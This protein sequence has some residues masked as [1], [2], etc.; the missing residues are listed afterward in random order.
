MHADDAVC[1]TR[2]IGRIQGLRRMVVGELLG[3]E[4]AGLNEA[5]AS[6]LDVVEASDSRRRLGQIRI[7]H[8]RIDAAHAVA[9]VAVP[10]V[11][12]R[13][14]GEGAYRG[15]LQDD[16]RSRRRHRRQSKLVPVL[17]AGPQFGS[18]RHVKLRYVLG[19]RAY[20]ERKDEGD[21]QQTKANR[22][23]AGFRLRRLCLKNVSHRYPS[24]PSGSAELLETIAMESAAHA[25]SWPGHSRM[26]SHGRSRDARLAKGRNHVPVLFA[27]KE[28]KT[29]ARKYKSEHGP[30]PA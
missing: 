22:Q 29:E 27:T 19:I 3:R 10:Q 23:L 26:P 24:F 17:C 18:R 6:A 4:A 28:R 21:T 8:F 12:D 20:G 11:A 9:L 13:L 25:A 15:S 7:I 30:L 14:A 16:A 5:D 1:G 2:N